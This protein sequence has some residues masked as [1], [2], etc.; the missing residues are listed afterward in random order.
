MHVT[1]RRALA[2]LLC[3]GA[4]SAP[5]DEAFTLGGSEGTL[6]QTDGAVVFDSSRAM[7]RDVY[8]YGHARFLRGAEGDFVLTARVDVARLD[9]WNAFR[10]KAEGLAGGVFLASTDTD[11]LNGHA[12]LKRLGFTAVELER[13]PDA[14]QTMPVAERT[15]GAGRVVVLRKPWSFGW[16]P[17]H[18]EAERRAARALLTRLGGFEPRVRVGALDTTVLR[19]LRLTAH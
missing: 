7:Q 12:F 1:G 6:A 10:L 5:A 14:R 11:S 3:A 13:A 8:H 18:P 2:A 19:V 4:L 17:G 9:H 16:D 15:L